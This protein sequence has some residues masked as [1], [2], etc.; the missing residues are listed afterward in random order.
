MS[1]FDHNEEP[2]MATP[3]DEIL[4]RNRFKYLPSTMRK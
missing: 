3:S 2:V 1:Y 4:V